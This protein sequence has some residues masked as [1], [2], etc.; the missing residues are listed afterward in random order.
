MNINDAILKL[1]AAYPKIY[2]ACHARH[3]HSRTTPDEI[4][5]RDAT[6]LAHLDQQT[7]L[8][9]T[10]LAEHLGINKSTLSEA[11]K[12]LVARG[13]VERVARA[14]DERSHFLKL[15]PAGLMAMSRSS[16]LEAPRLELLLQQLSPAELVAAV[17]GLEILGRAALN[18]PKE[19]E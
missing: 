7:P 2:L 13:Y 10:T 15:T 9:Q 19:L 3:R 6:L 4:S 16:V 5:Q 11:I 12:K 8:A 18:I 17:T 14:D 1:Q